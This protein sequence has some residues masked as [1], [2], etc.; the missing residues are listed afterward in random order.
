[1]FFDPDLD[2][3]SAILLAQNINIMY[4]LFLPLIWP[5][6]DVAV[7]GII[8]N[9]L[10]LLLTKAYLYKANFHAQRTPSI[11]HLSK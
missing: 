4:I 2:G 5:N 11:P 1:M 10:Y 9:F 8:P 3:L 6:N 7:N